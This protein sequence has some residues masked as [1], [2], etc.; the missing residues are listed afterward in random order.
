MQRRLPALLL[1]ALASPLLLSADTPPDQTARVVVVVLGLPSAQGQVMLQLARSEQDYESDGP[2]FRLA[3]APIEGDRAEWIFEDLPFGEY[4]VRAFHDAN[5][6]EKLDTNFLGVPKESYGF[7]NDARGRFGPA[8]WKDARF[9]VDTA[10]VR[11]EIT[12][13][14]PP[15]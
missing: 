4:A 14:P 7:S 3:R 11:Q 6:N 5:A 12:L 9:A 2:P 15:M 13:T 1:V 10:D 8:K